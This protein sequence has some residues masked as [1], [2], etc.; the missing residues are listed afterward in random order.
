MRVVVLGANGG[1]GQ[2][3]V[4]Q[5][6]AR[7]HDVRAVVRSKDWQ[8][9]EGVEVLRGDLADEAFLKKALDG[10]EVVLSALG[11][12]IKSLSP[13]AKPESPDFLTRSTPALV[14]AAKATGV[15][16]ILAISAGGVGDSFEKMPGFFRGFIRF[17]ALKKAY[18][19]LDVMERTL[20]ASGLEILVPRPSGLTDG[21]ATGHARVVRG[22]AGRPTISRADV[23]AWMLDSLDRPIPAD[24][25][26]LLTV[27]GGIPAA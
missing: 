23:A 17:T 10:R 12:R 22:Y 14:A 2:E 27:T 18:A 9:P 7:G 19:E 8:P 24:R 1:C 25:T 20:L 11:L 26:P 16:R 6:K 15:K 13:F 4:K 3:L 5:A 21:P